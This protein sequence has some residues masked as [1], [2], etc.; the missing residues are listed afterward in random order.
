[1]RVR[2]AL[3]TTVVAFVP[4][5][6]QDKADTAMGWRI[7]QEATERSQVMATL[8]Q[9]TDVYGPRVTG[10]PALKAALVVA[11]SGII[12]VGVY[13]QPLISVAQKLMAP[14]AALGSVAVK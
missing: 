9:L 8:H 10:S 3:L 11:L 1:M 14:L 7:R 13:P 6:A 2:L 5:A 12:F 4:L